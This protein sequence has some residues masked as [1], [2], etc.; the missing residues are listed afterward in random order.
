VRD[1]TALARACTPR[2]IVIAETETPADYAVRCQLAAL[3][4]RE[5][6]TRLGGATITETPVGPRIARAWP[7][8]IERPWTPK[9]RT[10]EAE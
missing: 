2:A 6:I 3:I 1:A 8:E 4:T 7:Q 5:S 9:I 10:I